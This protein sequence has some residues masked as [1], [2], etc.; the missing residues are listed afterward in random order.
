MR[1]RAAAP[2]TF[3]PPRLQPSRPATPRP[4]TQTSV[5]I[6]NQFAGQPLSE[7]QKTA[8][9]T[10]R[11]DPEMVE[12]LT[13]LYK[14]QGWQGV[15]ALFPQLQAAQAHYS[16]AEG[17]QP[18]S[19]SIYDAGE[20]G[21]LRPMTSAPPGYEWLYN[22]G[23]YSVD[24]SNSAPMLDFDRGF[25]DLTGGG[26]AI[27]LADIQKNLG[28]WRRKDPNFDPRTLRTVTHPI[29]GEVVTDFSQLPGAHDGFSLREFLGAA[30]L[31]G[32]AGLGISS[33]FGGMGI[34]AGAGAGAAEGALGGSS[35]GIAD[36]AGPG[37][38]FD[39]FGSI[40]PNELAAGIQAS[41][42][43]ASTAA[44]LGAGMTAT[45]YPG[46]SNFLTNY[47]RNQL[48]PQNLAKRFISSAVRGAGGG[49]RS[50]YNAQNQAR[51]TQLAQAKQLVRQLAAL[52]GRS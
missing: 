28:K 7:A 41:Q 12:G 24:E 46:G 40:V 33:L 49:A 27:P 45:G 16:G 31:V 23:T 26:N 32:G 34:G 14:R 15:E 11:Y 2:S 3:N 35:A 44:N 39:A 29:F 47:L 36:L 42:M 8:W 30:A 13:D 22:P 21:G 18:W 1:Q 10:S 17:A 19:A 38:T 37:M 20:G 51:A 52:R 5:P 25:G 4:V 43:G 50:A 6:A 9:D 48:K